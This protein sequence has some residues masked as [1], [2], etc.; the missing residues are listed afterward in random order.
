MWVKGKYTS[1]S[2]SSNAE[3]MYDLLLGVDKLP[4]SYNYR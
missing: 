3:L 1:K 4:K 2:G